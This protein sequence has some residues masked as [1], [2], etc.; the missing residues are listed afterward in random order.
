MALQYPNCGSLL[1][2]LLKIRDHTVKPC[3]VLE[4]I[5]SF[6]ASE[7][8]SSLRMVLNLVICLWMFLEGYVWRCEVDH[9]SMLQ[10]GC[11]TVWQTVHKVH[12]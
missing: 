5:T 9:G 11:S 1:H 6:R 8:V 12:V 2:S 3:S 10:N 7:Q 4:S